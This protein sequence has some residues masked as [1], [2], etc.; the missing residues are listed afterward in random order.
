MKVLKELIS[1]VSQNPPTSADIICHNTDPNSKTWQLYELILTG[2]VANDNEAAALLYESN[3]TNNSYKSLKR[4]L[5]IRLINSIF[6]LKF[7]S[8]FFD[9][10]AKAYYF[11]TKYMAAARIMARFY[12]IEAGVNLY[13]KVFKKAVEFE[14][15][16]YIAESSKYLW[17]YYGV[18]RG[19]LEKFDYY[20]KFYRQA[21][22]DW[23]AENLAQEY[24]TR[25]MIP[26]AKEKA[27]HT[28]I[29][30]LAK[31]FHKEL[32]QMQDQCKSPFFCYL[33]YYI[34]MIIYMSRNDYEN[35]LKVC[36]TALRYFNTKPYLYK[37]PHTTFLQNMLVCCIQLRKF[38]AGM[39]LESK[40]EKVVI[41]GS[42]NWFHGRRLFLIL[43]M[44]THQYQDGY[45]IF[46]QARSHHGFALLVP[47]IKELWMIYEGYIHLLISLDKVSP[48]GKDR[49]FSKFRLGKFLNSVPV[50][51]K[52]KR[53][54]NIPILIV[55]VLFMITRKDYDSA[56]DRIEA[57]QKYNVRHLRDKNLIRSNIFIKML[58]LAPGCG[59]HKTS[60]QRKAEK[61]LVKLRE[62]PLDVARQGHEIEIIPYEVLWDLVMDSLE[63]K[64]Q[65]SGINY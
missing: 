46:R 55:Q 62:T 64:F 2:K 18:R 16:L 65:H 42:H 49:F 5:R 23:H 7:K 54:L 11:C 35:T 17:S 24:Y 9:E 22:R 40:I 31:K 26:Y 29:H 53:G 21:A 41:P 63:R 59:F 60:I 37:A 36:D 12:A 30:L 14:F 45:Q 15:S 48:I 1:L 39:A 34:E 58:L 52:D 19:N 20:H 6:F 27:E 47:A 10:Y 43:A 44:H 32:S 50:F 57:I 25:L 51:S 13:L 38:K 56:V 61:Y 4:A 3:A 28:E 33:M 8:P